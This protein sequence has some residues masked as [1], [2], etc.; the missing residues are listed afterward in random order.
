MIDQCRAQIGVKPNLMCDVGT[1]ELG[2]TD[3]E[4]S[5]GKKVTITAKVPNK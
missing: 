3:S 1:T 5:M 4:K 2:V